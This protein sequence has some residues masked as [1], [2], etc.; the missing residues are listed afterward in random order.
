MAHVSGSGNQDNFV[1]TFRTRLGV[2]RYKAAWKEEFKIPW[3]EA[4]PPNHLDDKVDSDQQVANKKVSLGR[5]THHQALILKLS[6]VEICR[7]SER[8]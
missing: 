7:E 2:G 1:P 3:R 6:W 5:G 8:V 4:G